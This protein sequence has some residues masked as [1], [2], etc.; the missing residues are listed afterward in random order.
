M[1]ESQSN[2]MGSQPVKIYL[3]LG[4]NLDERWENLRRAL[5]SLSQKIHIDLVSPVYD[6]APIGNIE[7]PR[8]LNL[9]C[10]ATTTLAPMALLVLVKGIEVDMGRTPSL[11]NSPRSI[12]IDILFYNDQII[13]TPKLVIPHAKLTERAFVL[14]PLADIAP[15]LVHPVKKR[16]IHQLLNALKIHPDDIVKWQGF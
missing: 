7:Q 1:T 5:F 8:F 14:V 16:K 15:D 2:S 9:V 10:E 3:G 12:D 4:S 13:D 11:T 6:T